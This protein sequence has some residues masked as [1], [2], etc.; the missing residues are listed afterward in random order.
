MGALAL[1]GAYSTPSTATSLT[2]QYGGGVLI[3]F[4]MI[5]N[6]AEVELGFLY[7]PK[8]FSLGSK[9]YSMTSVQAPLQLKIYILPAIFLGLGGYYSRSFGTISATSDAGASTLPYSPQGPYTADDYGVA[10]SLGLRVKIV[11]TISFILDARYL[12]GGVNISHTDGTLYT[13]DIQALAG[14]RIGK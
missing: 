6:L 12:I 10:L 1:P 5:P 7:L 2:F 3:D 4:L 14:I 9:S 8:G 11:P 13:R